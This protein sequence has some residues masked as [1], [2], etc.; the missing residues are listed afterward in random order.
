MIIPRTLSRIALP[1]AIAA[2]PLVLLYSSWRTFRELDAQ[3][4]VYLRHRASLLAARLENLPPTAT[5]DLIPD[6]LARG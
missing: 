2:L 1:L 6:M 5:P 4:S 3:R